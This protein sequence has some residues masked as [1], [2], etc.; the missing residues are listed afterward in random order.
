MTD[1]VFLVIFVLV[2]DAEPDGQVDPDVDEFFHGHAMG[3]R[4]DLMA[5]LEPQVH[6][7]RSELVVE[8]VIDHSD[9]RVSSKVEE[10]VF[11]IGQPHPILLPV[12]IPRVGA[13][14]DLLLSELDSA[15]DLVGEGALVSLDVDHDNVLVG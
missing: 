15:G 14:P 6:G 2:L 9:G 10:T 5:D 8:P 3:G 4:H 11:A 13:L 1:L 7:A 12:P